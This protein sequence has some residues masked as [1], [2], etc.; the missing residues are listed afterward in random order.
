MNSP[1]KNGLAAAAVAVAA[2]LCDAGSASAHALGGHWSGGGYADPR[3]WIKDTTGSNWPVYA[4]TTN[5]DRS[6]HIDMFYQY[7]SCPGGTHCVAVY[8]YS[9]DDTNAG[10]TGGI[11]EYTF[12]GD[13]WSGHYLD[14]GGQW[15]HPYVKLND[16]YVTHVL[17]WK[18]STLSASDRESTACHEIGHA[19]GLA[20][21]AE[22]TSCMNNGNFWYTYVNNHSWSDLGDIYGHITS[23]NPWG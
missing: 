22:D 23:S 3:V 11:L 17:S 15:G 13:A 19:I 4:V 16:Y 5:W 14:P 2:V 6:S 1:F 8:E 7:G 9:S 20:H 12:Y 21:H 18:G 10:Y